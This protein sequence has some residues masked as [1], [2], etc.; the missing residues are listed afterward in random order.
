MLIS[1]SA[2]CTFA[3]TFKLV[4]LALCVMCLRTLKGTLMYDVWDIQ[5]VPVFLP[6]TA[7]MTQPYPN[8]K[9]G[10]RQW[11]TKLLRIWEGRFLSYRSQHE[12]YWFWY[13]FGHISTNQNRTEVL[14]FLR[15]DLI[16]SVHAIWPREEKM[17]NIFKVGPWGDFPHSES[18]FILPRPD[19]RSR[20][21][22][23]SKL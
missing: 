12:K 21:I 20:K 2:P 16:K 4:T 5:M 17:Y 23:F 15:T 3:S 13:N 9:S 11:G 14:E 7:S 1:Q 22:S 8:W 19:Q 18:H 6:D 10:L